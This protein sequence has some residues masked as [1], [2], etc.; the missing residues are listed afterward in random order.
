MG[1]DSDVSVT[2]QSK[3]RGGMMRLLKV[4]IGFAVLIIVT[5]IGLMLW[6]HYLLNA[7]VA[8]IRTAGAPLTWDDFISGTTT[9]RA[10]AQYAAS[11]A[12][13]NR[14][15]ADYESKGQWKQTEAHI[16]AEEALHQRTEELRE[17][18]SS[19]HDAVELEAAIA[20]EVDRSRPLPMPEPDRIPPDQQIVARWQDAGYDPMALAEADIE[21]CRR[22]LMMHAEPLSRLKQAATVDPCT[23]DLRGIP[24]DFWKVPVR[25]LQM[26]AIVHLREGRIEDAAQ[27]VFAMLRLRRVTEGH[28]TMYVHLADRAITASAVG[29][30]M[31]VLARLPADTIWFDRFD[32]LLDEAYDPGQFTRMMIGQRAEAYTLMSKVLEG[33]GNE[34]DEWSLGWDRLPAPVRR[35]QFAQFLADFRQIVSASKAPFP[36]MLAMQPLPRGVMAQM[37]FFHLEVLPYAEAR[38]VATI[39]AAHL[40]IAAERFRREHGRLPATIAELVPGDDEQDRSDPFTGKSLCVRVT[41]D[42][43]T[44]YSVGEDLGDDGGQLQEVKGRRAVDDGVHLWAP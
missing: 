44:I 25:L 20:A 35:Y 36:K 7:E 6:T 11:I 4:A 32:A 24:S 42:G 5:C 10:G 17:T 15:Y 22:L 30:M 21:E 9:S 40:A 19:T 43:V 27:T 38:A 12:E 1:S 8:Q 41:D 31:Q 28:R 2:G 33:A 16:A 39:R 18:L 14:I 23:L 37:S 13:L 3:P 26:E 34:M 29:V